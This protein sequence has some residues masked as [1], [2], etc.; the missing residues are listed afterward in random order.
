MQTSWKQGGKRIYAR[1]RHSFPVN[2]FAQ[3]AICCQPLFDARRLARAILSLL[4][5]QNHIRICIFG[6]YKTLIM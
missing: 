3:N 2:F 5:T 1:V 6:N 4:R